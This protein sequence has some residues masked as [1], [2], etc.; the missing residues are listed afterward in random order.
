MNLAPFL[1]RI[2]A[3][4]ATLATLTLA[5]FFGLIVL[6]IAL[7]AVAGF[8]LYTWFRARWSGGR[9]QPVARKKTRHGSA[10]QDIEGDYEVVS[11][12]RD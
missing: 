11:R 5:L 6:L 2:L 4:V 10:G 7:G 9:E 3:V 1:A 8:G 12:R